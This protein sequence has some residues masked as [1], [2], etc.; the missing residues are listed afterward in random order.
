[1]AKKKNSGVPP[2]APDGDPAEGAAAPDR[3]LVT[4][5]SRLTHTLENV[6]GRESL[7]KLL[8]GHRR[9]G[10]GQEG[11]KPTGPALSRAFRRLG[12]L[13]PDADIDAF[14]M[15]FCLR[16]GEA[17]TR[18]AEHVRHLLSLFVLGEDALGVKP[19]C[20][21]TQQCQ[22]C[23]LT[24]ECDHFNTPRKPEMAML[25]PAARMMAGGGESLS[26]AEL[27]AVILFGDKA[28]GQEPVVSTLIARYGR[29]RAVF[30]ADS[31]EF[32]A[33]RDM[34]KPQGLRLAAVAA[35]HWR[36]MAERR[37]E[38]LRIR[39]AQDIYDRYAPELR[40][41]RVEAA[42]LLMLDQQNNV[43]RDAWFCDGS[44]T[45]AHVALMDLLRPAVREF[46]VRVALVHNH[47][48]NDPSPSIADLEFTR[49]LRNACDTLDL[50]LVD[51]VV[52]TESG[53]YSFA[54]EGMLGPNGQVGRA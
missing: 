50:G 43:I 33:I 15:D 14:T 1:M 46:A 2:E 38:P 8:S 51:H 41:Y 13:G 52:V 49:R 40:D 42:V 9:G 5:F 32:M 34:T 22:V 44:P 30:R 28:T 26:D 17:V 47:P 53:Y 20:G 4:F 27:L 23:L 18:E 24:R 12:F 45:I 37:K 21:S 35:L 36:L 3:D 31:H 19:V 29:L 25:T 16:V 10:N 48:S 39:S 7:A 6:Y 54:E 11:E